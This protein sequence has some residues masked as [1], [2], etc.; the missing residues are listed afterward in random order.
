[1]QGPRSLTVT[2]GGAIPPA[3]F[4]L[5]RLDRTLSRSAGPDPR[6][7]VWVD[8]AQGQVL[9]AGHLQASGDGTNLGGSSVR[10]V[11]R[12]QGEKT[13]RDQVVPLQRTD[14]QGTP[15]GPVA[16]G[17]RGQWSISGWP[18]TRPGVYTL[19]VFAPVE[20]PPPDIQD[21]SAF[22]EGTWWDSKEFVVK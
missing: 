20:G 8:L 3:L 12:Y 19:I 14:S 16:Q 2:I 21:L 10:V 15:L 6:A 4:G 1:V 11:L 13:I 7:P 18:I 5:A 22:P 17:Q 9:R